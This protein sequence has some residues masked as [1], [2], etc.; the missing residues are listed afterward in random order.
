MSRRPKIY[1]RTLFDCLVHIISSHKH[2]YFTRYKATL[3]RDDREG[4]SG[5]VVRGVID[6]VKVG[7]AKREIE[8]L[9][10][11][12]RAFNRFCDVGTTP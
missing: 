11:P 8:R 9:Q 3:V 12:S 10:F 1:S 6:Y 4:G 7:I 2:D 5:N